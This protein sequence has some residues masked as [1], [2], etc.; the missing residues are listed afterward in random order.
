[1]ATQYT[2]GTVA[3]QIL[4]AATMNSIGAAWEPWTPTITATVG[5]FTSTTVTFARYSQVQKLITCQFKV[6]IVTVGTASGLLVMTLPKTMVASF[7]AGGTLGT[8]REVSVGGGGFM[9]ALDATTVAPITPGETGGI[10]AGK[11]FVGTFTY[12]A[13]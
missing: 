6:N 13:A 7:T 12:E 11:S 2:G 4:T 10:G 5:T 3:G 9:I 8:Y 1:M